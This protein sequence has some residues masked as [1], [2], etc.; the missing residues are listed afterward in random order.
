LIAISSSRL[1]FEHRSCNGRKPLNLFMC[2]TN[3]GSNLTSSSTISAL[4]SLFLQA[5][6]RQV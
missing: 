6:W 5:T 3:L 1:R 4:M 2:C